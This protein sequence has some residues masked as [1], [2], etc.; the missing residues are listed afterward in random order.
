SPPTPCRPVHL[1]TMLSLQGGLALLELPLP[2]AQ[3][4]LQLGQ[5]V[6]EV[7]AERN[8]R[9]A[10]FLGLSDQSL[11]L[12]PV[13]QQLPSPDRVVAALL[14]LFI[15]GDMHP[16]EPHFA[17]LHPPVCLGQRAAA[18]A[19][20]LHLR[21]GQHDAFLESLEDLVV[22]QCPAIGGDGLLAGVG[23]GAHA[24]SLDVEESTHPGHAGHHGDTAP[25]TRSQGITATTSRLVTQGTNWIVPYNGLMNAT[26]RPN[27]NR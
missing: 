27:R 9:E 21:A 23:L 22:V 24:G 7:H 4:D 3:P 26:F 12:V 10:S 8:E 5:A 11:D 1:A 2:P 14:S 17:P 18:P 15:R 20:G 25:A 13:Q 19:K 16:L 6:R